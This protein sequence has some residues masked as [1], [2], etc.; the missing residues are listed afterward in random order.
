MSEILEGCIYSSV[1]VKFYQF[2]SKTL[3]N[4][5]NAVKMYENERPV[6]FLEDIDTD[7]DFIH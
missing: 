7:Y 6:H 4:K 1:C 5:S 3:E 2:D